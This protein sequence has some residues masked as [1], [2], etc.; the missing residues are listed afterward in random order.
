MV[1]SS[2][3][4]VLKVLKEFILPLSKEEFSVLDAEILL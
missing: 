1:E 3:I 4:T 2:P